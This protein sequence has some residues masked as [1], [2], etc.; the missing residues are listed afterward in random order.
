MKGNSR[1]AFGIRFLA[2][3]LCFVACGGGT[4]GTGTGND[5]LAI[6]DAETGTISCGSSLID[7]IPCADGMYCLFSEGQCGEDGGTGTCE[8]LPEACLL[9]FL[10]VCGC[11]GITYSNSCAAASAGVSLRSNESCEGEMTDETEIQ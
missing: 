6:S 8:P 4:A 2:G 11:D 7:G 3:I 5:G 10:P 9:N 1:D